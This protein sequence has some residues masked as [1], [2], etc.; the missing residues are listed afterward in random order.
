MELS[1]PPENSNEVPATKVLTSDDHIYLKLF[2]A[3]FHDSIHKLD[4]NYTLYDPRD[5]T[6]SNL[7]DDEE[8]TNWDW[9]VCV[10]DKYYDKGLDP[11]QHNTKRMRTYQVGTSNF[12][13]HSPRHIHVGSVYAHKQL[14]TKISEYA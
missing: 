6:P 9:S 7:S 4:K 2:R 1:V 5:D 13:V 3:K 14:Q 10:T 12:E 11:V 8:K